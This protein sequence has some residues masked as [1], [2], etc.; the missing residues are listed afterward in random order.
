ME[1]RTKLVA[2]EYNDNGVCT[3]VVVVKNLTQTEYKK[4]VNESNIEKA[5]EKELEDSILLDIAKL[6]T[7]NKNIIFFLAK[8]IYDSFVDRGFID[9]DNDFELKWKNYI[10]SGEQIDEFPK[11]MSLI[12]ERLGA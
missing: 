2:C 7:Q 6:H 1:T 12:I 9:D 3:N 8:C 11:F 4:L 5:K 10:T